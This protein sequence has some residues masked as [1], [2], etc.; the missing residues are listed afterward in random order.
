MPMNFPAR[1]GVLFGA[2]V[3]LLATIPFSSSILP[4]GTGLRYSI[5]PSGYNNSVRVAPVSTMWIPRVVVGQTQNDSSA[6]YVL[7]LNQANATGSSSCTRPTNGSCAPL[8]V[9]R[10]TDGGQSFSA[11]Q[12]TNTYVPGWGVDALAL[13]N[14]T[15]VAASWG[16]W[17]LVSNDSGNSW[18]VTA[19]LGHAGAPASLTRDAA[20]G[21]LYAVWP[22]ITAWEYIQGPFLMSSSDD[23]G[24]HWRSPT[25]ILPWNPGGLSPAIAAFDNHVVVV[26]NYGV[27]PNYIGV[28]D[29]ADGGATWSSVAALSKPNVTYQAPSVAV[30]N[31]G[32]F[33]VTWGEGGSVLASVSRDGGSSWSSP[34]VVDNVPGAGYGHSA[35]F[36]N[37]GRLYVTWIS[38]AAYS[39]SATLFVA[40][41]DRPPEH[42]AASSF[43]VTFQTN[44]P[45]EVWYQNNLAASAT[46]SVYVAWES[47]D[48]SGQN[49]SV[50][51]I[52]VRSVTGVVRGSLDTHSIPPGQSVIIRLQ[53]PTTGSVVQE[54]RW[55]GRV[56]Q[57]TGLA[58]DAY[59]ILVQT[60][61]ASFDYGSLPVQA[62][63][64][65]SFTV[66]AVPPAASAQVAWGLGAGLTAGILLFAVSLSALQY[67][68]LVRKDVLQRKVRALIYEY[69]RDNPGSSFSAIRN[70]LGLQNGVAA[71]HLAVLENQG[72]LH[73]K[74]HRRHRWYYP[75]GDVS[76]WKDLPLSPL[77]REIL[78]AVRGTPGA[79]VRD[80]ARMTGH[81]ASSVA[82]NLKGLASE[83]VLRQERAG[84][85]VRYF[86]TAETGS[87]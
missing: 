64:L 78:V 73:S 2:A 7:G 24:Y 53:D 22:T 39:A 13:P 17:I 85:R 23:G 77:Q 51:G 3:V 66:G 31:D 74:M 82:Y 14:G 58:P 19:V 46:G 68:R 48:G 67:T 12:T 36:D 21:I 52:F 76:L 62:W 28:M 50:N 18:N 81:R 65:T 84:R 38:P 32:V 37:R 47:S 71:Y 40:S 72:L 16:P 79:G 43:S 59:S 34:V 61:N 83:G 69:I 20:T 15:L 75:E 11:P 26:L 35:I 5:D 60:G 30:S 42:F 10:S 44:L 55:T 4:G 63:S 86:A 9:V 1:I 57:F 45:S 54:A 70:D 8:I 27:A 29:S 41:S 33:A 25:Q 56:V 6:V 80:I 49:N 87:V